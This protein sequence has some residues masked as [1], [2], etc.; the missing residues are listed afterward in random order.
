MSG[1]E[2]WSFLEEFDGNLLYRY[3]SDNNDTGYF[4]KR[5]NIFYL[6]WFL[7]LCT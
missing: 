1:K 6:I 7:S 4:V 2:Y 5:E 3:V